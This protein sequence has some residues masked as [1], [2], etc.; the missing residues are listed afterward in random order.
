MRIGVATVLENNY[1]VVFSTRKSM[2]VDAN[3]IASS[4]DLS[5]ALIFVGVMH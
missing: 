1:S 4:M 5:L 3:I 2:D